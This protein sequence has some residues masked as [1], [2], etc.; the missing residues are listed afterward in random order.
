M[1]ATRDIEVRIVPRFVLDDRT[2]AA[3]IA[4]GWTPPDDGLT[5]TDMQGRSVTVGRSES[6]VA[7]PTP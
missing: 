7:G 4:L 5:V 1:A 2:R 6:L 3:L